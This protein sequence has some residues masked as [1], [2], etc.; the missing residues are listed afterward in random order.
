MM[1]IIEIHRLFVASVSKKY[2]C[3]ERFRFWTDYLKSKN[4]EDLVSLKVHPTF[5]RWI[6]EKNLFSQNGGLSK[7]EFRFP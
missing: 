7:S 5:D 2:S 1:K 6:M 3:G 4:G